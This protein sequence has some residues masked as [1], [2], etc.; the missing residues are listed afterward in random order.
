MYV[1]LIGIKEFLTSLFSPET[2]RQFCS[3]HTTSWLQWIFQLMTLAGYIPIDF[4]KLKVFI[5][6]PF[7]P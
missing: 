1:K 3:G 7:N 5:V 4:L 2:Q 6:I